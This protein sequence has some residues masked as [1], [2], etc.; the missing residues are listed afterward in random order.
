[1]KKMMS[2]TINIITITLLIISFSLKSIKVEAYTPP[3]EI[4]LTADT[5]GLE[6]FDTRG[7]LEVYYDS[8]Y[9]EIPLTVNARSLSGTDITLASLDFS[10]VTEGPFGDITFVESRKIGSGRDERDLWSI[11]NNTSFMSFV[12]DSTLTLNETIT[13]TGVEL[14]TIF[15]AYDISDTSSEFALDLLYS[16]ASHYIETTITTIPAEDFSMQSLN[17]G[18][19]SSAPSAELSNIQVIGDSGIEYF[20]EIQAASPNQIPITIS[21]QD[22]LS[23][24]TVNTMKV[25]PTATVLTSSNSLPYTNGE[26]V[27]ITVSDGEGA[28]A[29][30]QT[31][32][33]LLSVVSP[34]TENSLS[35]LSVS[36]GD[37][38]PAFDPNTTEY[39]LNLDYAEST[40][41]INASIDSADLSTIDKSSISKTFPVGT[42]VE[43]F[44]VT[45]EDGTTKTYTINV[46]REAASDNTNLTGITVNGISA[47]YDGISAFNY[48]LAEAT[49][50]FS[51]RIAPEDTKATLKYKLSSN[52]TDTSIL[53]NTN[54]QS[55]GILNDQTIIYDILVT[56]ENNATKTYT[57]IISRAPSTNSS[58]TKLEIQ[59]GVSTSVLT[60]SGGVYTYNLSATGETQ[61]TVL[62][63]AVSNS[64]V[65]LL[66]PSSQVVSPMIIDI[67]SLSVGTHIYILKVT[68]Q[69]GV[70][71]SN[72][73][74]NIVKKSDQ[75][76]II[77]SKVTDKTDS[78]SEITFDDID[79]DY[80]SGTFTYMY[81]FDYEYTLVRYQLE[82]SA[83]STI[84]GNGFYPGTNPN[85]GYFDITL[86]DTT[87]TKTFTVEAE[88]GSVRTYTVSFSRYPADTD[89]S[90][91]DLQINAITVDGFS[92]TKFSGYD[93]I[94][95]PGDT[96]SVY[97]DGILAPE[98]KATIT[99]NSGT[100]QQFT[101]TR[102]VVKVISIKVTAQDGSS[103]TYTI[104]VVAANENNDI[105]DIQFNNI[106]YSF[107]PGTT[108][109]NLTV[110]YTV[111]VT[112]VTVLTP[113]GAESTVFGD[114]AKVL[115]VGN[116]TF[117]VYV[118]S[119][120]GIK[121]AEY[122]FN[123]TRSAART[124]N[125][126]ETLT[127]GTS[128][129]TPSFAYNV[130]NYSVRVDNNVTEVT[131]NA[132]V[133][134]EDG[135]TIISGLGSYTLTSGQ[136]KTVNIIVKAEN[137]TNR[138]Y[139]VEI[140]RA[141]DINTFDSIVVD[142]TTYIPS[143]FDVNNELHLTE[144]AYSISSLGVVVN[145]TDEFS[146][147]STPQLSTGNLWNL[148]TGVNTFNFTVTSQ[149]GTVGKTYKVIITRNEAN[150]NNE[151]QGLE[152]LVDGV[153]L[154]TGD[155]AFS[156]TKST[157]ALRVNSDVTEV[158]INGTV[159]ASYNSSVTGT[160]IKELSLVTQTF[161]VVVTAENGDQR[162]YVIEITR[163][164][165]NN[166]ID[167]IVFTGHEAV[168]YD[169]L[170]TNYDLG[171]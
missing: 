54:S 140:L 50:T 82:T 138:T 27:T 170:T 35:N 95:V 58:L 66:N 44:V 30:T 97:I 13:P 37:I 86:S 114:G 43:T 57:L 60:P 131:V 19:P 87:Q 98:S 24:L 74:L 61:I 118:E 65:E 55:F 77:T 129:L 26:V 113:S 15:I 100:E 125:Y 103:N 102:G 4:Y 165:D 89:K 14:A 67:Q 90:L 159:N 136:I 25:S 99:Y 134:L 147:L 145:K 157:Y 163:K 33:I 109:Y 116:N 166:E 151:L 22:S 81:R 119:E 92:P 63:T 45:A 6:A 144:V 142:G 59:E 96:A 3:Y 162:T 28:S 105:T 79:Y 106:S 143:Q 139:T 42:T 148:V 132:T 73:E 34:K 130:Y 18:T 47:S 78:Y 2:I 171:T 56:A 91:E 88:D 76:E 127:V 71:T 80:N 128:A 124:N 84:S 122:T 117:K 9:G 39:T 32:E 121:G 20:N 52:T 107:N 94:I 85:Q 1:M 123:I 49:A 68:A 48:S 167:N 21:Y 112:N 111:G 46:V 126:L 150:T 133:P 158:T 141:N 40:T 168:T 160:G 164:N 62:P 23:R 16:D 93:R 156:S 7:D 17:V 101:L 5:S 31:Y 75:K 120:A 108:I 38:T 41:M 149:A 70:T 69:D 104:E 36:I 137:G 51:F 12:W 29:V 64:S 135:S 153:N 152:V 161:N 146:T 72:Y 110:D 11:S 169:R 115:S 8:G 83:L 154:L 53:A 10:L 155:K